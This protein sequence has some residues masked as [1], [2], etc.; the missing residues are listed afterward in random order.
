MLNK[1]LANILKF[2]QY[3]FKK[4]TKYHLFQEYKDGLTFENQF[5]IPQEKKL[6]KS[7]MTIL[8]DAEYIR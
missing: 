1:I 6:E 7:H 8:T 5:N 3:L 4:I 2:Q